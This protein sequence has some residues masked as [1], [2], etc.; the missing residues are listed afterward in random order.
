LTDVGQ[1]TTMATLYQ[2]GE[3]IYTHFDKVLLL[4]SGHEVFFGR[5]DEASSYFES[6]GFLRLPGQTTAEY[7]TTVTDATERRAHPNSQASTIQTPLDLARAFKSSSN[8]HV[9]VKEIKEYEMHLQA[10]KPLDPSSSHNLPYHKQIFECLIREYL[11]VRGQLRVYQTKWVTTIILCLAIGSLYFDLQS[12]SQ[13]AFSRGS[14][15]F[16]ALIMNG[17]LQ[18]PELFDAHTNRPVLERQG[19]PFSLGL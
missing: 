19:M 11:I 12:N 7:L 4:D 16:F 10:A 15:L 13:G 8:Y 5:V 6:L 1:K 2:A 18:F 17:W 3:N 9:L 14:I